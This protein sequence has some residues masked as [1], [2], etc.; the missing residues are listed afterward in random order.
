MLLWLTTL[1]HK[2]KT[3]RATPLSTH[4]KPPVVYRIHYNTK[5]PHCQIIKRAN[6]KILQVDTCGRLTCISVLGF[7]SGSNKMTLS[8]P[9]RLTPT[10]PV[11]VVKS[12]MKI[13]SSLLKR[14]M[15]AW[16]GKITCVSVAVVRVADGS[17]PW[18]GQA[19]GVSRAR[20][21]LS[22]LREYNYSTYA[23]VH[24]TNNKRHNRVCSD[25]LVPPFKL[26][27]QHEPRSTARQK[28][29]R[30]IT[31]PNSRVRTT[32][33][34]TIP[35]HVFTCLL[36]CLVPTGVLP[37]KRAWDHPMSFTKRSMMFSI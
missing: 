15:R 14:S 8:A 27:R 23:Y 30:F 11:R 33:Y 19:T 16:P 12:M 21:T 34:H 22:L 13:D 7:Q 6:D 37:S 24:R 32:Q 17:P 3:E 29:K 31:P 10:P 4:K 18:I 28:K 35:S 36:T 1:P 5:R 25:S 26:H 9:V 20:A 2:P